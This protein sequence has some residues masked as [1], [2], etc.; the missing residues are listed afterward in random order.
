MWW[1]RDTESE[2]RELLE[3]ATHDGPDARSS[4]MAC[5]H[6]LART[7]LWVIAEADPERDPRP[8]RFAMQMALGGPEAQSGSYAAELRVTTASKLKS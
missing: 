2:H 7:A 3:A 1:S 4:V 8:I 6:H 5:V